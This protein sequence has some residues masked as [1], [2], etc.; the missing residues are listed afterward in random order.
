MARAGDRS[1][2]LDQVAHKGGRHTWFLA[3]S[4]LSRRVYTGRK[5]DSVLGLGIESGHSNNTVLLSITR[6]NTSSP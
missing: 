3:P 4:P 5:L 6:L 2:E 1:Q